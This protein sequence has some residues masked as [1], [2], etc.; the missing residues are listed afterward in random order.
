MKYGKRI[1]ALLLG[2]VLL[3]CLTGCGLKDLAVARSAL[4]L[5]KV[6]SVHAEPE[7]VI[8]VDTSGDSS[9]RLNLGAGGSVDLRFDRLRFQADLKLTMMG[10]TMA[11][12]MA[13]GG[14]VD[15]QFTVW[16][17]MDRGETWTEKALCETSAISE[18]LKGAGSFDL[19]S[20]K[21]AGSIPI[22]SFTAMG[23]EE[24][25][26]SSAK[27]YDATFDW[28]KAVVDSGA[29][30]S[31]YEGILSAMG[32]SQLTVEQLRGMLDLN[33]QKPIQL[34]L[35]IGEDG[36]MPVKGEA[37]LTETVQTLA[38][39]DLVRG[40]IASSAGEDA[41]AEVS[42]NRISLAVTLSDFDS[43]AEIELPE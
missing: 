35:W 25:N 36:G 20:L 31:L 33:A 7:A 27:R 34:S 11:S 19:S 43:V 18:K 22:S 14:D 28:A 37:D 42:I 1:L 23:A 39:S 21:D 40:M 12:V 2:A 10:A 9:D 16:Y 32:N 38:D 17:S 29:E 8:D 41:P 24:V 15:G 6:Q 4:K 30:E 5:L 26:G 13:V 3:F